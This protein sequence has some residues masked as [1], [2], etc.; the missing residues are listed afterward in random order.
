M[1]NGKKWTDT[2]SKKI[3]EI[4][5]S[6]IQGRHELI[7]HYPNK[8]I[9]FNDILDMKTGNKFFIPKDYLMLFKQ[10]F[11]NHPIEENNFGFFT[12]VPFIF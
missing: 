6:K 10:L 8:I 3:C 2:N 11:P 12:G 7:S 5:Y 1:F 4:T 9:F